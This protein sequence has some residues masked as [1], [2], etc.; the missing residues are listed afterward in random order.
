MNPRP[1]IWSI[2]GLD[3]AGG[4]GLSADQRA[5]DALGVH[6]CPVAAALTAQHSQG[7]V[8]I[9]PVDSAFLQAQL[10]ALAQDLPPRAIKTG[11]LGSVQAIEQVAHWVDHWR[12]RTPAGTDPHRQLALIVD[13]V[14]GASSGGAAFSNDAIVQAYRQWLLPRATVLT[15]NRA[16]ARRL[17]GLRAS[18]D[19]ATDDLPQT[20]RDLQALGPRSVVITGG[21]GPSLQ[22]ASSTP[23]C[24]DWMLTPHAQ[25]WL[26]APRVDTPHTHGTGCTFASGIAAAWAL[27]HV[28]ADA[29]VLANMLTRHALLHGHAAGSGAGPVMAQAGFAAGPAQGGA[30]LP[31]LGLG[32]EVPWRLTQTAPLFQPFTPP[33]DGLYGILADGSQIEA[34]LQAGL[35]CVQLRH[36]ARQGLEAHLSQSL[37]SAQQAGAQL[38]IN[39]HWQAALAPALHDDA[40]S[41]MPQGMRLGIHLGQEDLTALTP[42]DRDTLLAAG[43]HVM[44]GLSSHSLW[45]LARAAGCGASYIACG[46]IQPTTTK[47]M[48]WLPQGLDNLSWWIR[49]SPAPVVAIGGLLNAQDVAHVATCRPA[50]VCVVRGLGQTLNQMQAQVPALQ[51]AAGPCATLSA[52]ESNAVAPPFTP[53]S[54]PSF[55]PLL[56]HPVLP[57]A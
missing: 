33:A 26:S 40:V 20:A 57:P 22:D 2:A 51:K 8:A 16:E 47:D 42:A 39:D 49:H 27:G 23:Y 32:E 25:G 9:S 14:L 28:E 29:I 54:L 3:T 37:R 35:R 34:A 12:T 24:L 44:L 11:L 1:I 10:Q 48:P 18:H 19:G 36:K 5:A 15:P 46:P 53:T 30:T 52:S 56:P 43:R 7:V 21:D 38:F 4:A 45:E 55:S 31:W 13:P 6:L 17:L 50:A 41:D